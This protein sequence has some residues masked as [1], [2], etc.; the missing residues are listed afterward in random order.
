VV[1]LMGVFGLLEVDLI[2]LHI[3]HQ[4]RTRMVAS[5]S[6]RATLRWWPLESGS[7]VTFEPSRVRVRA[8]PIKYR[9]D[10][11]RV[12]CSPPQTPNWIFTPA[13]AVRILRS[14]RRRLPCRE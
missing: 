8:L 5:A 9:L 14:P 3:L 2:S 7:I 12:D 4:V 11:R 1:C 10:Q 13:D 6:S